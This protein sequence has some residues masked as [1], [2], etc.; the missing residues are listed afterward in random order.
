MFSPF[1]EIKALLYNVKS[2]FFP[3]YEDARSL[4]VF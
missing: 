4:G 3:K 1:L 2:K